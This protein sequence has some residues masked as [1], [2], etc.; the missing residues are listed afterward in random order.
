M[1][2]LRKFI[3][4]L[5][6]LAVLIF[7]SSVVQAVPSLGVGT[8]TFNCNGASEY[9]EC[10]SGNLDEHGFAL[11]ASGVTDGISPFTNITGYD[12]W[13]LAE[14]SIGSFNFNGQDSGPVST[15][16][17]FASYDT[18][19]QGI[20]LGQVDTNLGWQEISNSLF[21]NGTFY[22]LPGT[23]TYAGDVTGDWL[24]LVADK[25]D[26]YSPFS[27]NGKDH[28]PKSPKTTSAVG[29]RVPEPGMLTLFGAGL[30]GLPLLRRKIG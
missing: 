5:C 22:M 4:G 16:G 26:S 6:V 18:P 30:L 24:F 10:F 29:V 1:L 9:W 25:G 20:N 17:A 23:L 3:T 13:L 14:P 28:D 8:G 7:A 15:D 11:P 12:I 27:P 2:M 19:Y 21:N